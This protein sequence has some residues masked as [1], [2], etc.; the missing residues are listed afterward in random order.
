MIAPVGR[1]DVELGRVVQRRGGDQHRGH[2][3]QAVE[4]RDQLRHRGHRDAPRDD[5]PDRAADRDPEQNQ[6]VIAEARVRQ[7]E[8][9]EQDGDRH[10]GDADPVALA[11]RGGRAQAAQREDE[12]DRGREIAQRDDVA[13][14]G[15]S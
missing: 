2:A 11:G 4:P 9:R 3:D 7:G 10:A 5:H 13:H 6:Q 14:A 8:Q 12:A 1:G 15:I